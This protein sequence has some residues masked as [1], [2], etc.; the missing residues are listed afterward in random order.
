MMQLPQKQMAGMNVALTAVKQTGAFMNRLLIIAILVISTVPLYAQG[1]TPNT[2]KLKADAQNVVKI[3]SGDKLK[4]QTYCE[5]A[6]LSDQIDEEE[7]PTKAEELSHKVNKLEEKL[8]PEYLALV[9][10]L[11]DIDPNSQDAQEI[12][13]ILEALDRFCGD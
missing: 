8:G 11:K 3:I 6:E 5:I 4:T 7:N 1:Q 2:A 10:G 9:G 13:S 12:G